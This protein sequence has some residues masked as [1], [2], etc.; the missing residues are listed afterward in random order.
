MTIIE[1]ARSTMTGYTD[2]L[3][4]R[5]NFASYFTD[6]VTFKLM[7]TDQEMHGRDAVEGF[8]RWFHE[9]A[10]DARPKVKAMLVDGDHGAL[11]VEFV[12]QHVAE[13]MGKPA[14]GKAVRV[15]Y[16]AI[17]DL[18]GDRIKALRIYL[19]ADEL[20]RQIS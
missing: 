11:E 12:G 13:F 18:E 2:A 9:Q 16:M 14:S 15:P 3:V 8:I 10:F 5:G 6:D 17:Y 20:I 1:A 4:G 19:P 7:W